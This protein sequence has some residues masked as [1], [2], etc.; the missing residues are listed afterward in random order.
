MFKW[1]KVLKKLSVQD[2]VIAETEHKIFVFA[3][4]CS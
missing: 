3:G 1:F 4:S 2:D